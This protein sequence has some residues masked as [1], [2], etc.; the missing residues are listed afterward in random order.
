M[1]APKSILIVGGGT[2][3]WMAA[4]L[5]H[6][7]WGEESKITLLESVQQGIIGVGEGSTPLLRNFFSTLGIDESQWMPACNAS[8]KCGI[9]FPGWQKDRDKSYFHPFYSSADQQCAEM[10]FKNCNRRR[11]HWDMP[12]HPDDFFISTELANQYLAPTVQQLG[13]EPNKVDSDYGYHFDA[14]LL[15]KFLSEIASNKGIIHIDAKVDS[16][17]LSDDG[18]ITSLKT[19][20]GR[21]LQADLF[22]DGS[23]F[24]S[25]LSKQALN[26][27]FVDYSD[28]LANDRAVALQTPHTENSEKLL[29]E[30]ISVAMKHGWAWRIPLSSRMGNGYVYSSR[31]TNEHEAEA[32]LRTLLG[33]TAKVDQKAVHLRWKPGRLQH[34][35][36][37]NCFAVGLSQG[38]LEPLE[39]AMLHTI[40][41]T[42]ESFIFCYQQDI[43][44]EEKQKIHNQRINTL[45]DGVRDYLQAHYLLS[46]RD[47]SSYWNELQNNTIM[48][49]G[50]RELISA[51]D[52][53]QSIEDVMADDPA[54]QVYR[55]TSWYCLFSGL[56]RYQPSQHTPQG[57]LSMYKSRLTALR[58][59]SLHRFSDH[60]QKLIQ[61][62]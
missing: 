59:Q 51:W 50:L 58:D 40:Q 18:D 61:Y 11:Q 30:T 28:Y 33:D 13:P 23:G 29:S 38:F 6:H 10:F 48:S 41:D 57:N 24:N 26:I 19:Q 42:I 15:A 60:K 31:H 62:R 43:R 9:R 7:A 2:A 34:N 20:C 3:G 53:G 17:E 8:Y 25:V 21:T 22:V 44:L 54:L 32:D 45:I 49:T 55:R 56:E 14:N 52:K 16:V 37:N 39:A 5:L 27:S 35:W 36:K 1:Q 47:D 12:C 46:S 4:H